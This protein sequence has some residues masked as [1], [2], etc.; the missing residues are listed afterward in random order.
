MIGPDGER[1]YLVS[2]R[3]LMNTV[4]APSIGGLFT[5]FTK[6]Y[7]TG[8]EQSCRMD[9]CG[10]TNGIL[11]GLVCVTA[12]CNCIESWAALILGIVGS[13]TYSLA[14]RIGERYKIDDPLEGF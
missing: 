8:I 6:S 12:S 7:I 13:I 4:L 11:S 2:E 3:A 9:F 10:L 5:L 14:V 1:L